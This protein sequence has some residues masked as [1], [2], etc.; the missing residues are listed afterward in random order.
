[1][2]QTAN[3][4]S[5]IYRT[6]YNIIFW[7]R[8]YIHRYTWKILNALDC[9]LK[10]LDLYK[11]IYL[12]KSN[13][14]FNFFV[15]TLTQQDEMPAKGNNNRDSQVS[16]TRESCLQTIAN[17]NLFLASIPDLHFKSNYSQMTNLMKSE[18][19]QVMDLVSIITIYLLILKSSFGTSKMPGRFS[20]QMP[21]YWTHICK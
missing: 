10:M 8:S 13:Q 3:N 5:C 16:M 2:T 12:P 9:F 18:D 15:V 11:K 1:M 4:L 7:T 21:V 14:P 19:W 17:I 20:S 6:C